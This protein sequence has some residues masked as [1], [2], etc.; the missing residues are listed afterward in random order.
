MCCRNKKSKVKN[1]RKL[2]NLSVWNALIIS[3]VVTNKHTVPIHKSLTMFYVSLARTENVYVEVPLC[4]STRL[5][6]RRLEILS[7][8][9]CFYKNNTWLCFCFRSA[10]WLMRLCRH[11]IQTPPP[12]ST[13]WMTSTTSEVKTPTIRLPSTPTSPAIARTFPWSP[14]TWSAWPGTTGTAT[15]KASTANWAA[16]AS[17]LPT[18]SERKSRPWSTRRTP[19]QTNCSTL[20]ISKRR[21]DRK[22]IKRRSEEKKHVVSDSREGGCFCTEERGVLSA[23]SWEE[24]RKPVPRGDR[25]AN[26]LCVLMRERECVCMWE[27]TRVRTC[28]NACAYVRSWKTCTL[29][30]LPRLTFWYRVRRHLDVNIDFK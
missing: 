11:C 22:K 9:G 27:R 4:L 15:P 5:S 19:R 28:V 26:A 14:A 23:L 1:V 8:Y 29:P 10:V 13:L 12:S 18:R 2:S 3:H 20:K 30:L 17:T 6:P 16:P 7:M 25:N 21:N 24:K